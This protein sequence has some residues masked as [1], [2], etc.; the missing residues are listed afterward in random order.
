MPDTLTPETAR[1]LMAELRNMTLLFRMSL[2][3]T[4]PEI[5]KDGMEFVRKATAVLADAERELES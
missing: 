2:V 4:T 5:A 3:G 1:A